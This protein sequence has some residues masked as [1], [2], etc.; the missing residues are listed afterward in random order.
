MDHIVIKFPSQY[1]SLK[2]IIFIP[3]KVPQCLP[4]KLWSQRLENAEKLPRSTRNTYGI[5]RSVS[6][7]PKGYSS[8]DAVK[9]QSWRRRILRLWNTN[10]SPGSQLAVDLGYDKGD[11]EED[12]QSDH[13]VDISKYF[14]PS[15][16]TVIG[17]PS[18]PTKCVRRILRD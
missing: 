15:Y 5:M 1:P 18:N 4:L 3:R 11:Y 14:L 8:K 6:K 2:F 7:P 13:L 10:G 16:R 9:E 17:S 12:E